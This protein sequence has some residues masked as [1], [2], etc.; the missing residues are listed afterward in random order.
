MFYGLCIHHSL[1]TCGIYKLDFV[2]R[3][4]KKS[5]RHTGERDTEVHQLPPKDSPVTAPQVT[6]ETWGRVCVCLASP[7]AHK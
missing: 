2:E 6:E 4:K 3:L 1:N 7:A 5:T